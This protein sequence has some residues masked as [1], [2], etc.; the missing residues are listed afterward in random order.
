MYTQVRVLERYTMK[1]RRRRLRAKTRCNPEYPA[2]V[3]MR[4]NYIQ[5]QLFAMLQVTRC[6]PPRLLRKTIS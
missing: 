2:F 4:D 6:P 5:Y 1:K 3:T